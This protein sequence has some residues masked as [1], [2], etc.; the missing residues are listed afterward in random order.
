MALALQA[1]LG[2]AAAC[3]LSAPLTTRALSL[4]VVR[5][6]IYNGGHDAARRPHMRVCVERLL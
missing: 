6:R 2:L 5:R 3:V 1:G 4:L